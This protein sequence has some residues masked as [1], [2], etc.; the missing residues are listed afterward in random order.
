MTASR[1]TLHVNLFEMACVSHIVHGMWRAPGNNRHRFGEMA[2]WL[3]IARRAES[4]GVDAIFLADVVGVYDRFGGVEAALR[5]GLQI[6]NLDPLSIVPAMAAVTEHLGFA[7]T[8]STTYEPP[9]AFA[10]RMS[11][12]DLLTG[13]RTG[14]NIVTSY[15]PNAARNFGL[16]DEVPHDDRYTRA[17]EYLEVLY[18]LWEGSW[19][20]DAIVADREADIFSDPA[21][22]HRIHHAGPHFRVEGPHLVQPTPQRTPV[23]FQATG[24]SRGLQTAARHAEAIFIGGRTRDEVCA[25]IAS[26]RAAAARQGRDPSDLK[27]YVMA[28]LIAGRT[29]EEARSKLARY[30]T[31]YSV[32]GALVHAQAELD[33]RAYDRSMTIAQALEQSGSPFGN[34]GRRFGT[35]QTIGNA[36][37][38]ISTFDEGRFFVVGT[39]EQ[40]ADAVES[41]L[42]E[43]GIDG[44]NMRQYH[45]FETL[46]D[47]AELIAPELRRR[48]RLPDPPR[49]G[50]TL[51]HRL[52]GHDLLP[53][54]HPAA[55]CRPA[56]LRRSTHGTDLHTPSRAPENAS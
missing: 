16:N 55:A 39:P 51:R 22:V 29:E 38:Q 1:K 18:K 5:L 4:A 2:F 24:S 56:A 9:F 49:A 6:P 25:N 17:D 31:F 19:E 34:M 47:Y 40:I 27:F 41:W 44:I 8:F 28:G 11:T 54:T 43:D 21:R 7:T 45:T 23:L 42:D 50:E 33:L 14:W 13:G 37:D 20:S 35:E 48:G 15:L 12:L 26:T 10:R 3:D 46:D 52:F 32:E 36:I 30:R 53:E